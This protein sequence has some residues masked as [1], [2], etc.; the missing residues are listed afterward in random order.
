MAATT[1]FALLFG[2]VF[3]LLGVLLV[4][5]GLATVRDALAARHWPQLFAAIE[6]STVETVTRPKG[7]TMYRP[8]VTYAYSTATGSFTSTRIGF[9]ERLYPSEAAARKVAERYAAG[10]TVMARCHPDNP[11]E[12]V[13]E[14][15]WLDGGAILFF[16]L[17]CW[18]FPVG[19]ATAAGVPWPVTTG[20]LAALLLIPGTLIARQQARLRRARSDGLYPPAGSGSDAHVTALMARGEKSLAIRLYRELHGGG[21]K[22]ARLAVEALPQGDPSGSPLP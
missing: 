4:G 2:S 8:L 14:C 17:L 10:T 11:A 22:D 7:G 16:G 15:R 13:L 1:V 6:S 19:A 5:A 18:I 3:V 9:A 20:I 21:L 12:A